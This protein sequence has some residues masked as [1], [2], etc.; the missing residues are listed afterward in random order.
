MSKAEEVLKVGSVELAVLALNEI[1]PHWN[2]PRVITQEA[3]DTV[4]T[5]IE[6][7]GFNQPI[8]LGSDK[9]IL[10]GHTRY[11]ALRELGVEKALCVITELSSE[12]AVEY[13][14]IDN[15]T[16]ELTG[17]RLDFLLEELKGFDEK[18]ANLF[19][20]ELNLGELGAGGGG[21]D[22]EGAFNAL[23][24]LVG[25][26]IGGLGVEGQEGGLVAAEGISKHITLICPECGYEAK[27]NRAEILAG[28]SEG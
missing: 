4:R 12:E 7:Y 24:G 9:V 14:I 19:F 6:M 10:A 27:Y 3:V 28:D 13:R 25:A 1:R 2:N 11:V 26:G 22:A 18:V 20:P 8:I 16:K 17:W 21:L 5:S 23:N 15:K